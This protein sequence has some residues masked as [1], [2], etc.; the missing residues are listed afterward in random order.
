MS[1]TSVMPAQS[2]ATSLDRKTIERLMPHAPGWV[3][4]DQVVEAD[5]PRSIRT[6]KYVDPLDPL[7]EAHFRDGP[8][9]LPGVL[10]IEFVSQSAYLIGC[11]TGAAAADPAAAATGDGSV[12]VL[13]RC[14]ARFVSPARA[15]D[16]LTADVRLVDVLGQV[17]LYE[18]V[19]ASGEREVCRATVY[20]AG[21]PGR[22]HKGTVT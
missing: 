22:V 7:I 19:V 8:A 15:G 3:M 16:L 9:L 2:V 14:S 10:L 17:S 20:A 12:R 6:Q 4:V 21:L 18:G 5:P 13:A 1:A 11:L